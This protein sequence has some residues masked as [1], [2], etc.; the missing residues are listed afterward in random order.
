MIRRPPRSTRVR[1]S[2][3]SDVYKRQVLFYVLAVD[4][5]A[6]GLSLRQIQP[7][8]RLERYQTFLTDGR[9]ATNFLLVPVEKIVVVT[10]Q[11]NGREAGDIPCQR[12]RRQVA[13]VAK[14]QCI[15]FARKQLQHGR[16]TRLSR[17]AKAVENLGAPTLFLDLIATCPDELPEHCTKRWIKRLDTKYD[18]QISC[19]A[20]FDPGFIQDQPGGR[21]A[22]EHIA[23][24]ISGEVRRKPVKS[25]DHA[26]FSIISSKGNDGEHC[27]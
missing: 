16:I 10:I 21:T 14:S 6:G 3:A 2:A 9:Y 25:Y 4:M 18:I 26:V 27:M 11:Q 23:I 1:S 22:Y 15:R 12:N 19:G 5:L 17:P 8:T 13:I 7:G 20:R 24:L